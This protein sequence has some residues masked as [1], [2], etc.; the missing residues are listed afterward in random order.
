MKMRMF[1][2]YFLLLILLMAGLSAC[3]PSPE[4]ATAAVG[5]HTADRRPT[6][7][8]DRLIHYW[9]EF[10]FED[11]PAVTNPNLA[12]QKLVDFIAAMPGVSDEVR[13]ASITKLLSLAKPQPFAFSHFKEQL[14][15]YLYDP[16]SPMRNDA[17]YESVLQFM[18]D[19]VELN[20]VEKFRY[21][22]R[23]N[24]AAKNKIGAP[25]MDF[26]F[27][28]AAGNTSGLYELN[29]PYILLFFYEPDCPNCQIAVAE[30]SASV[31]FAQL[32]EKGQLKIAAIYAG[33]NANRWQNYQKHIPASWSN[34]FDPANRI[35]LEEKYDLRASPT[36]YLLDQDKKVLLKDTD[37]NKT[38][39]FL[40]KNPPI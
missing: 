5:Q 30:L 3:M 37:L 20:E 7:V 23:L 21:R 1:Y 34:G 17:Y 11:Q 16:N 33:T 40:Y 27:K 31:P 39:D 26:K 18:L 32:I 29:A 4:S 14:E 15:H 19:S 6:M 8:A 2:K 10:N 38:L 28:M 22:T 25:A 24:M 13:S 12:E 36:I 9:D 35:R